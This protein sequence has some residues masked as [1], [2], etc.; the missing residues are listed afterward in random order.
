M[1][2]GGND[3][4]N[5]EGM[6]K[7]IL[8]FGGS[9][10]LGTE[11]RAA[12][13]DIDAEVIAPSSREADMQ[14][15]ASLER[16]IEA[17]RPG[18]II[19]LA[20]LIDVNTLQKDQLP[21]WRINV[22]GAASIMRIIKERSLKAPYIFMST[23]YVFGDTKTPCDESEKLAPLNVYGMTKAYAETLITHYGKA[24]EAPFYILRTGWIYSRVRPTFVD[25]VAKALLA[26]ETFKAVVDQ[27]GNLTSAV[28]L[29]QC[30]VREFV[31]SQ[32]GSGVYHIINTVRHEHAGISR[33]EIACEIADILG[34]PR[35]RIEKTSSAEVFAA[36]RPSAV[37]RNTKLPPLRDW[38]SALKEYLHM[39]YGHT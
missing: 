8:L 18:A 23:N 13:G 31:E 39:Q 22:F 36:K 15:A 9:G 10:L 11:L 30:V 16:A 37:L 19:N 35:G 1:Q 38:K 34:I 25:E 12:L 5:Y 27:R 2:A 24:A 32:K 26:G 28:D 3:L 6:R 21:G 7:K 29:A 4:A 33:Y 20:A 14:D 17:Y